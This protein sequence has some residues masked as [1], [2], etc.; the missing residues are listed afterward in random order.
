MDEYWCKWIMTCFA[1]LCFISTT[2]G[3]DQEV[4]ATLGTSG[5]LWGASNRGKVRGGRGG[6][7]ERV[8]WKWGKNWGEK[9][10]FP[11]GKDGRQEVR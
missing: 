4:A 5:V 2:S 6:R 8:S 10:G 11:C 7:G 9:V 3:G 1:T